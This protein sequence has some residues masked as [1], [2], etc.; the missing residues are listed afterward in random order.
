MIWKPFQTLTGAIVM[1]FIVP[2]VVSGLIGCFIFKNRV[3]GV[4][5]SII[6]RL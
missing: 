3:K 6:R 5:F 4:Y 1:L 2:T